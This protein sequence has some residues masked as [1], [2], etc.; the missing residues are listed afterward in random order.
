MES[1]DHHYKD[2]K[3]PCP[4]CAGPPRRSDHLRL[5]LR[6]HHTT[7]PDVLPDGWRRLPEHNF[8]YHVDHTKS[9]AEKYRTGFCWDCYTPVQHKVLQTNAAKRPE[10]LKDVHTCKVSHTRMAK[11]AATVSADDA[12]EK[13][14]KKHFTAHV[15]YIELQPKSAQ[16]D[17][18]L[19]IIATVLENNDDGDGAVQYQTAFCEL[20]D[21]ITNLML[22]R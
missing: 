16:K 6:N 8:I 11:R 19:E 9:G 5:H 20:M 4:L 13:A 18:L 14:F 10:N 2:N 17:R 12:I 21:E 22:E 3:F 1:D 7:L 15:A